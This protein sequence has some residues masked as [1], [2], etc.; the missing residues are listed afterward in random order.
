M[1]AQ[2]LGK[3]IHADIFTRPTMQSQDAVRTSLIDWLN[4]WVFSG[5]DDAVWVD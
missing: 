4:Q 2:P 5:F 1:D 3:R